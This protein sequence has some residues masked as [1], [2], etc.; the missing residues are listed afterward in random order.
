MR[1][2][3]PRSFNETNRP[4]TNYGRSSGQGYIHHDNQPKERR[5]LQ[6]YDAGYNN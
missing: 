4:S 3:E 6:R 2:E 1:R 5:E